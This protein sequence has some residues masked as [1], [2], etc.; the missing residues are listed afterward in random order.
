MEQPNTDPLAA[1]QR[2][3]P[4]SRVLVTGAG[5]QLG[6]ALQEA[7]ADDDVLALAHADWDVALPPPELPPL[8]LVLHA[9][10]WTD[11]DGAEDDPQGATAVDVRGTANVGSIRGPLASFSHG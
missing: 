8:D 5:G 10:A 4:V 1:R 7:F 6:R 11:V 2:R 3:L 9:A